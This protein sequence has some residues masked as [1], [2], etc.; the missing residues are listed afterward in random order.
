MDMYRFVAVCENDNTSKQLTYTPEN[1]EGVKISQEFS[2]DYDRMANKIPRASVS[3]DYD[4]I[5]TI[6]GN[7]GKYRALKYRRYN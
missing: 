4:R 3:I 5:S 6:V 2:F 1:F 7:N